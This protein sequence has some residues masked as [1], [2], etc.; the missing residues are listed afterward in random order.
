L[1]KEKISELKIANNEILNL[2]LNSVVGVDINPLAVYIAR[3]N[4]I[5]IIKELLGAKAGSITIP[6]F[7]S[8][9]IKLP[10]I[11]STFVEDVN[12]YDIEVDGYHIQLP[13]KVATDGSR[14]GRVLEAIGDSL[15]VYQSRNIRNEAAKVLEHRVKHIL[16]SGE[17]TVVSNTLDTLM[18]LVDKKLDTIW[19]FILSN[20][21]A[22]IVLKEKRFD[23][24][25]GN[26]PW[27]AMQYIENLNYQDFL[28]KQVLSYSLLESSQVKLFA[29]I[30]TAT[31]FF[32]RCAD[33]Y[34]KNRGIIAFVM[35]RSVLTGAKFRKT[36]NEIGKD[37]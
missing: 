30:E 27:I 33:L 8:D 24:L 17:F 1:L 10:T 16:S 32:N 22:P 34:L 18:T 3:A 4:Y 15:N 23:I 5:M 7:I 37:T 12:A 6:I 11:V 31:L 14:L 25:I 28:K 36:V 21:Y 19:V 20:V 26:P 2:I 13:V 29:N 35:P 9:T